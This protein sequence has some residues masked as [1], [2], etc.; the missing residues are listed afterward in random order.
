MWGKNFRTSAKLLPAQSLVNSFY[1]VPL[2]RLQSR[3]M[4]NIIPSYTNK[5]WENRDR[6]KKA[7]TQRSRS[8]SA[9]PSA[10]TAAKSGSGEMKDEYGKFN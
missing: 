10:E 4:S 1:L 2:G 5:L 8:S 6:I 9:P 3:T 7:F